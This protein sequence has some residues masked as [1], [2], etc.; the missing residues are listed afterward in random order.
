MN[1]YEKIARQIRT[2]KAKLT[3]EQLKQV[4]KIY[5]DTLN[6]IAEDL[7]K[8]TSG[9][10]RERWLED[11]KKELQV[12]LK[13]LKKDLYKLSEEGILKGAQLGIDMNGKITDEVF[14]TAGIDLGNHFKTM[15]STIQDNVVKDIISGNLYKDNKTLSKRIW[16]FTRENGKDIQSIIA[17]GIA[18]KKSAI[19]LANDLKEY[20][21]PTSKRSTDWG[22]AYPN[23]R[24]KEIDYNAMRLARTSINH[25][26]QNASIQGSQDN[27]FVEGI[28]WQSAL[29]H[30]TC[31]LCLDRHGKI[32]PKDDVPLDH[33][34]GLCTMIPYIPRDLREIGKE[35][36][37][38]ARGEEENE[39]LDNWYY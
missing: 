18:Q 26:Y 4:H 25:A 6:S 2:K 23:L 35:I 38:W 33:P 28:L 13:Q 32:F 9:T 11:Y 29:Q 12:Y 30:R 19:E 39:T 22:S 17:E 27:P 8:S 7:T 16:N 15:F 21:K 10:L 31:Q 37:A 36:G 20:V 14:K 24:S 3:N 5:A 34:N 1:W